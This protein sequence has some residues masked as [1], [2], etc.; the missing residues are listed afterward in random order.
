M[1]QTIDFMNAHLRSAV[2]E[3]FIDYML[4]RHSWFH[5][6]AYQ[7]CYSDPL[8]TAP[9]ARYLLGHTERVLGEAEMRKAA[10]LCGLKWADVEHA[11]GNCTCVTVYAKNLSITCHRVQSPR[12]MVQEAE[13]RKQ[14]AAANRFLNGYVLE[15]SLSA[16]LPTLTNAQ[17]IHVYLLHGW[18]IDPRSQEKRFFMNFAVP[19]SEIAKYCWDCSLHQLKQDFVADRRST[20]ID[21][22]PLADAVH[23]KV[24]KRKKDREE[25]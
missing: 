4:Q 12:Q 13:S 25:R 22:S 20:N 2:P 7:R 19:D 18:T 3:K 23:P 14:A 1:S 10:Q 11:G 6:E 8:M 16:P 5:Q 21:A 15:G 17:L 24:K 9:E